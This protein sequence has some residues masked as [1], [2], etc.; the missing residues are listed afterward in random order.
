M[1]MMRKCLALFLV[2]MMFALLWTVMPSPAVLAEEERDLLGEVLAELSLS[3][4][5]LRF[6]DEGIERTYGTDPL[7]LPFF[8]QQ[9][10]N[11][12]ATPA[13]LESNAS[14]ISTRQG[15]MRDL[16]WLSAYRLGYTVSSYPQYE[17]VL[18][19]R[20]VEAQP[21]LYAISDLHTFCQEPLDSYRF[22]QLK[23]LLEDMPLPVQTEMARILY[24][25][26]F[27]KEQR[28]KA[29]SAFSQEELMTVFRNPAKTLVQAYDP[30]T[31]RMLKEA[32][33]ALLYF[34]SIQLGKTLDKSVAE[35]N[36]LGFP[37]DWDLDWKT[38]MGRIILKGTEKHTHSAREVLLSIDSGGDDTYLS[39]VGATASWFNP[40]SIHLDVAGNDRYLQ[41]EDDIYSQGAGILGM[42]VLM[43]LQ[44]ND[45]YEAVQYAQGFGCFGVGV[46]ADDTGNDRYVSV[47]FAQGAGVYGIGYLIDREGEDGYEVFSFSQG[48]GY[49]K[50]FGCLL[51]MKGNDRYIANDEEVDGSNP[52]SSEHNT[53]F[54]QGAGFGRRADLEE[55]NSMSGGFGLLIDMEGNDSYSC[56]VFGQGTGYWAGTGLL[57]DAKGDDQYKGVWYVQGGAAHFAIAAL[58]DKEGNDRYDA[59]LNMA[60]G[61]GHDVSLG[62]LIDSLGNDHY[63][64]PNLALGGGNDNGIGFF[65]DGAGDDVYETRGPGAINLGKANYSKHLWGSW[66]DKELSLGLFIDR[67]GKD[68]YPEDRGKDN[69]LWN[70][71]QEGA[72]KSM[73][74]GVDAELGRVPGFVK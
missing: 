21:L 28:D 53:S 40:V 27:F 3:R 24:A 35:L 30:L 46:L 61:A 74:A 54:C 73:G 44:G 19:H 13:F 16:L 14:Y 60:Q 57:F 20:L 18:D 37:P 36:K 22:A 43:D 39:S 11:P 32:N 68:T 48:F 17:P 58:I 38:P 31:H 69:T 23:K 29:F 9:L 55:G 25:S 7:R 26:L 65:V 4:E 63:I 49:V 34:A 52:Q 62:F 59:L 70:Y 2:G 5:D 6:T 45:H 67:G 50:G 1:M 71:F 8:N 51:D 41:S 12:L 66:R 64:S 15:S 42:G 47:N 72:P 10:K 33:F 56:G